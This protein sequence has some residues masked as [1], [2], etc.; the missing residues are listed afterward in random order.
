MGLYPFN[1][2]I[3]IINTNIFMNEDEENLIVD[4]KIYIEFQILQ[5]HR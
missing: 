4:D 5:I 2:N 3:N 1:I